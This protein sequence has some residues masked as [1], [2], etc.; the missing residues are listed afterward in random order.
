MLINNNK[1][2]ILR[3]TRLINN[4]NNKVITYYPTT[5]GPFTSVKSIVSY[6]LDI[7]Q[8]QFCCGFSM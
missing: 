3:N 7:L 1:T 6:F 4:N 8:Y 5:E 2:I